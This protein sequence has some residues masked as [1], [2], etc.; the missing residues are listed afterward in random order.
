M[1]RFIVAVCRPRM[2]AAVTRL[3]RVAIVEAVALACQYPTDGTVHPEAGLFGLSK[4]R[5]PFGT[6]P[7]ATMSL[8]HWPSLD[9]HP[10]RT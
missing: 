3:E 4:T 9:C 6:P 2:F 7:F 10:W 1:D 8:V 5:M